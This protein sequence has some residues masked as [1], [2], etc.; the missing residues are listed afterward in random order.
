MLK[1]KYCYC[2]LKESLRIKCYTIWDVKRKECWGAECY[3]Y[4]VVNQKVKHK[5]QE[6][7]KISVVNGCVF[8]AKKML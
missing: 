1:S 5:R 2:S 3:F 6:E 4:Y 7:N 8:L